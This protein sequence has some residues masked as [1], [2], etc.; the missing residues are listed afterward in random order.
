MNILSEILQLKEKLGG[1]LPLNSSEIPMQFYEYI[2]TMQLFSG[3]GSAENAIE[4]LKEHFNRLK[5][6]ST[7]N[8]YPVPKIRG[9]FQSSWEDLCQL[10][11]PQSSVQL[12]CHDLC[13]EIIK[14]SSTI[15]TTDLARTIWQFVAEFP[16]QP[17]PTKK[18]T[19]LLW[20]IARSSAWAGTAKAL[21]RISGVAMDDVLDVTANIN[22]CSWKIPIIQMRLDLF[23]ENQI[24]SYY[25][26]A[27]IKDI[28]TLFQKKFFHLI[29]LAAF[30]NI[31]IA[32]EKT[33][34]AKANDKSNLWGD[35]FDIAW[36]A[37]NSDPINTIYDAA[38]CSFG[39]DVS[40]A[41]YVL[42][43]SINDLSTSPYAPLFGVWESGWWPMMLSNGDYMLWSLSKT[44]HSRIIMKDE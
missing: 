13:I 33:E 36:A 32:L 8:K 29:D 22:M 20:T 11:I 38:I 2:T 40:M 24:A 28:K 12:A 9:V 14:S 41:L 27:L 10:C 3:N 37:G 6:S 34:Q 21:Q 19:I 17:D 4:L 43:K 18:N 25:K 23:R 39:E 44:D 16:N 1:R 5:S 7:A 15:I 31:D 26:K 35:A 42:R 30:D